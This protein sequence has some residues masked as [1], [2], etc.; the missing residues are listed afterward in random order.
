MD[1]L[2]LLSF[3]MFEKAPYELPEVRSFIELAMRGVKEIE[4]VYGPV[5]IT[6]WHVNL[7]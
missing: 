6:K 7:M 5:F 2:K 1:G 3:K 4:K